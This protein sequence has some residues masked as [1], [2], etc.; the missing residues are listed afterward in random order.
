MIEVPKQFRILIGAEY[1]LEDEIST[2]ISF[3]RNRN[4]KKKITKKY[5]KIYTEC[6]GD[7]RKKTYIYC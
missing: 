1:E 4:R 3:S 2:A 7:P 6:N 5:N